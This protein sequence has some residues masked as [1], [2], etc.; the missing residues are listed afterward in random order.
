MEARGNF[1][2]TFDFQPTLRGDLIEVRPLRPQDFAALFEAAS[3]PLIWEQHPDSN[4]HKKEVFGEFF[5]GAIDSK[6][7]FAVI[8]RKSGEIIGSSRYWN[9]NTANFEVEIGWTFLSRKFWGGRYNRELKSLMLEHAF[10]FVERVLFIVGENNLRSRKAVENIGGAY[11]KSIV[12]PGRDGVERR[13][14][15]YVITRSEFR[16]GPQTADAQ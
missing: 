5:R 14:V 15:V 12:R 11:L 3:D 7:A 6:G 1:Q 16:N 13:N 2:M 9:L 8:E 4:R 10:R